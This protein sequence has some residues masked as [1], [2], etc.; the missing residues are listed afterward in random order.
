MG[1]QEPGPVWPQS[2]NPEPSR[3]LEWNTARSLCL[4][5]VVVLGNESSNSDLAMKSFVG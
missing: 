3:E 4:N 1:V 5:W 2:P